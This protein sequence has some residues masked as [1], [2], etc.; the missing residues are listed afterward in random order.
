VKKWLLAFGIAGA[1]WMV[2]VEYLGFQRLATI[3]N[4]LGLWLALRCVRYRGIAPSVWT[5]WLFNGVLVVASSLQWIAL[6]F[7]AMVIRQ[8]FSTGNSKNALKE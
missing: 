3:S 8:R 1:A 5:L 4:Y 2:L 6:G 7:V